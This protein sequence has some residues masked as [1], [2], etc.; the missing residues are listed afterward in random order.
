MIRR[1]PRSTL[2]PYTTLFRSGDNRPVFWVVQRGNPPAPGYGHVALGAHS[3]P[4]VDAAWDAGIANGGA[5]DGEPGPRP[6][7]GAHHY[8]GYLRDPD[9]LRVEIV[10]GSR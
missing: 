4:A 2:F 1:P 5:D 8:A 6:Q 10:T 9:G 7:Y 3:R